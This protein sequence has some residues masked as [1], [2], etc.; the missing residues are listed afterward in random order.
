[1]ASSA[2]PKQI[3]NLPHDPLGPCTAAATI[4][5]VLGVGLAVEEIV[6]GLQVTRHKLSS[7]TVTPSV[8]VITAA[9]MPRIGNRLIDL[10][11]I[12]SAWRCAR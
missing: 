1:M 4:D 9:G 10:H 8:M 2:F 6:G 3:V 7:T 11:Q 5:S 12:V